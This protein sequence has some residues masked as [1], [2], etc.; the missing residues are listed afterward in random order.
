VLFKAWIPGSRHAL[1]LSASGFLHQLGWMEGDVHQLIRIV[2]V[3]AKDEEIFDR[4]N[5]VATTYEAAAQGKPISGRGELI[6]LLGDDTVAAIEKWYGGTR[7]GSPSPQRLPSIDITTDAGAADAFADAKRNELIF[8]DDT[9]H[10]FKKY[11][12]VFRPISPVQVQGEAKQFMQKQVA[13]AASFVPTRS[14]LSKAKIDNL[15]IL[16]RHR[17]R[18][19]PEALDEAKHLV[20]CVDGKVLDLD[21][22]DFVSETRSIVTRTLRCPFLPE[23]GCPQYA[24]FLHQILGDDES[25]TSFVQRAVGYS[26]SG[27]TS[28]QCFFILV[29]KG[30]NGK[31]TFL[32]TLQNVFGDYAATTPAQTLMADR[33]GNQQTN[34]LAKLVGV[35]FVAATETEKGQRLAESKIKRITGGDRIAC[36]ELYETL[37]EYVPQ[38]KLWLATNDPPEFSGG[39]QSIARRIRVIEFP[40]TFDEA[41][42]D[43]QLPSRLLNEASGILN[44]ALAGYVEWKR[45][46]LSPPD[47]IRNATRCYRSDNDTVG[48]FIEACCIEDP[49]ARA[50]AREL[51]GAYKSWCFNS[52]LEP[53]PNVTFGKDLGRRGFRSIKARS[54]NAWEGLRSQNPET[55]SIFV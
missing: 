28:E 53:I 9:N 34:D 5:S 14:L 11:R 41:A 4:L 29:G 48:Q 49:K 8:R 45:Q 40:V 7:A 38:F 55:S 21:R 27:Y 26:L 13:S 15:L 52:G 12:H 50:T 25:V 43:Q 39:D 42:Q 31:S 36:R 44:W 16:S 6:Q 18:V 46:G 1:S 47:R 30:S 3:Q 24:A 22:Q 23:A 51:Y 33:Y 32:S 10:W 19:E 2:C 54:G 35:R 20:G 17:F 37:F